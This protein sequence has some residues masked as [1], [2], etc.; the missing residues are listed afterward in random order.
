M[1]STVKPK[2]GGLYS[3]YRL[4]MGDS[5]LNDNYTLEL[6]ASYNLLPYAVIRNNQVPQNE[7]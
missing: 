2:M 6:T 3:M 5:E 1:T 4:F 7:S